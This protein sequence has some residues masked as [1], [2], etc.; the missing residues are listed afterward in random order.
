MIDKGLRVVFKPAAAQNLHDEDNNVSFINQ[1][2][3]METCLLLRDS[4]VSFKSCNSR[5]ATR[6]QRTQDPCWKNGKEES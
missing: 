4:V 6:G 5:S 2:D 3:V 1:T